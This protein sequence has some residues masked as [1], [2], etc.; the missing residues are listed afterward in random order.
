MHLALPP[1]S[2]AV[3][4]CQQLADPPQG[5][6]LSWL[7]DLM[8]S[9]CLV[10][11]Q[12]LA[13]AALRQRIPQQCQGHHHQSP[14]NPTGFFDEQRRDKKHGGFEKAAPTL[15]AGW[16]FIGADHLGLAHVASWPIGPND[17]AGTRLLVGLD[18]LLCRSHLGL[19]LP[20]K[21][22]EG[23]RGGGPPLACIT[24]GLYH[25]A[26][27]ELMIAPRC[28]QGLQGSLRCLWRL[29]TLGRQ[30]EQWLLDGFPFAL[31]RLGEARLGTLHGGLRRAEQP[32]LGDAVGTP[33][34]TVI[35]GRRGKTRP[36]LL[37]KRLDDDLRPEL[38][39]TRNASDKAELGKSRGGI[40]RVQGGICNERPGR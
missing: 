30:V 6:P 18:D 25:T 11:G 12:W 38:D 13:Q 32:A 31:L 17:Q 1:H 40:L 15:D 7:V 8:R 39:G 35:A 26:G 14:W 20:L 36:P 37:R 33:L 27:V 3:N 28:G 21:R 4:A 10:S 5:G 16:G 19:H 2:D 34:Q 9:R 29:K 22:L 24:F 23:P